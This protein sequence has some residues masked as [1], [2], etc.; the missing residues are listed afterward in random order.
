MEFSGW[1]LKR[2]RMVLGFWGVWAGAGENDLRKTKE[3]L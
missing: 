1:R 2:R 3:M